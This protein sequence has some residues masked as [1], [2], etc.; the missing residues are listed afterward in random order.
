[1]LTKALA[2][3]HAPDKIRVN[4]VCPGNIDMPL[5]RTGISAE[6]SFEEAIK[7]MSRLA[8]PQDAPYL[9][10][11]LASDESSYVTGAAMVVDNGESARADPT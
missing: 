3:D 8:N 7:T 9:A 6:G 10:L 2:I 5:L 4:C 1:L 11:Y